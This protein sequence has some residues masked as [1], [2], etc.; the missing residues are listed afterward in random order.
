MKTLV[1]TLF[2]LFVGSFSLAQDVEFRLEVRNGNE[3][4]QVKDSGARRLFTTSGTAG[5]AFSA[6]VNIPGIFVCKP[7][8]R[9]YARGLTDNYSQG[10]NS[11]GRL[12]RLL[13]EFIQN[14]S[15]FRFFESRTG[16]LN[17]PYWYVVPQSQWSTTDWRGQPLVVNAGCRR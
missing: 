6:L 8:V 1:F 7:G 9:L 3:V 14:P 11:E 10:T 5:G 15:S 17:V 4:W 13:T 12:P 16:V 2:V